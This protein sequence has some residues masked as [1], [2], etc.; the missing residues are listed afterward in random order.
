MRK[1]PTSELRGDKQSRTE[2]ACIARGPG[3][4]KRLATLTEVA[5]D[6]S[7]T[8]ISTGDVENRI[9]GNLVRDILRTCR[10][11]AGRALGSPANRQVPVRWL[12]VVCVALCACTTTSLGQVRT[13]EPDSPLEESEPTESLAIYA[14]HAP[15]HREAPKYKPQRAMTRDGQTRSRG[16]LGVAQSTAGHRLPN[17]LC[18]PLRC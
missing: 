10:R 8:S 5:R 1:H 16:G 7:L 12:L 14:P 4:R 11:T 15:N 6:L 18:A 3:T 9:E 2:A 13:S 17:G